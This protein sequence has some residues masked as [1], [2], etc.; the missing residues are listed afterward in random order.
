MIIKKKINK[1]IFL[2]VDGVLNSS[3]WDS[4]YKKQDKLGKKLGNRNIDPRSVERIIKIC[5]ETNS[6]IVLSSGWRLYGYCQT[7][8]HLKRIKELKPILDRM[9][10]V[11]DRYPLTIQEN[12]R[13]K[14][15]F[16]E[17]F[18]HRAKINYFTV[19]GGYSLIDDLVEIDEN[20]K[21]II[22]DDKYLLNDISSKINS[23]YI[24][25]TNPEL[26]ITIKDIDKA[27]KML[28]N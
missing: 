23:Q 22:I 5:E 12:L 10:G 7:Y 21:Y 27:I 9:V 16:I 1:I 15:Y 3:H 20:V 13:D 11:T 19:L 4:W 6:Y 2:D 24:L 18:L 14:T 28:N 17:N 25:Q 8:E 26:G